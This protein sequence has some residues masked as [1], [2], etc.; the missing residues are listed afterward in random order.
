MSS[1]QREFSRIPTA[2]PV[3]L[4]HAGGEVTGTTRDVAMKG[5]S[6][7]CTA[8]E[9]LVANTPVEI[10]IL[11]TEDITI[12]AEGTIIRRLPTGLAIAITLL[13]GGDSFSHLQRLVMLNSPDAATAD[14]I[15]EELQSHTGILRRNGT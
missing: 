7:T 6:V 10:A 9:S 8:P 13:D 15:S 4:R 5:L 14:R 3:R 12:Q 11:L 2:L 1:E